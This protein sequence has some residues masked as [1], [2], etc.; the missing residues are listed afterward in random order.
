[1]E[2]GKFFSWEEVKQNREQIDWLVFPNAMKFAKEM[3]LSKA[4]SCPKCGQSPEKL[5]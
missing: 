1:M 3:Y 2:K 4:K 5:F